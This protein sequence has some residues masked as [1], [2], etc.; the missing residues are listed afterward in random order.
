MMH[1]GLEEGHLNLVVF[2]DSDTLRKILDTLH[3]DVSEDGKIL[4]DGK[5]KHCNCCGA[6]VTVKN[7][8]NV[9]PGS[10]EFY[11]DNPV[12]LAEYIVKYR[13]Y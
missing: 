6:E 1:A 8:G 4:D 2:D 13:G 12:C 9:M 3:V 11:C 7:L 10:L 5:S